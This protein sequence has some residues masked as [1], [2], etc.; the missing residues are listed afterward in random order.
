MS[1]G[2]LSYRGFQQPTY[3]PQQIENLWVSQGG[4]PAKSDVAQAIAEAESGGNAN[5]VGFFS[6]SLGYDTP[7]PQP[8]TTQA[9]EGIW[10]IANLHAGSNG[11]N[12]VQSLLNPVTN[13][14]MAVWLSNNGQD[15]SKWSTF[16]NGQYQNYL[17]NKANTQQPSGGFNWN[18]ITWG[19]IL[20]PNITQKITAN[21]NPFTWMTKWIAQDAWSLAWIVIGFVFLIIGFMFIIS[22]ENTQNVTVNT[23][24]M[25]GKY[26]TAGELIAAE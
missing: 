11:A 26:K 23:A 7:T 10:Q 8:D 1:Y 6:P 17:L 18:P 19:P 2:T 9:D 21:Y 25:I 5:Q 13:A 22:S 24:K 20:S 15:W 3:S 12:V 16:N 14:K 4:D